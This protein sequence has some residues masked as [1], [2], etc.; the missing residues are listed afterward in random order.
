MEER[1]QKYL[2]DNGIASRRAAEEQIKLGNVKV[3]GETAVIGQKIDTENDTVE[4]CGKTVNAFEKKVYV[5]LNKPVGYVTTMHDE[6]NRKCVADLVEDVGVRIYPVGRLDYESEGLLIM[7][8]DGELTNRLTHP[9]YHKPKT[10]LVRV[11]G[12]VDGDMAERLSQPADIDGYI[13]KPAKVSV[14][15]SGDDGTLLSVTISEGRNRQIRK[16]CEKQNL[17]V[18]SLKR[19]SLGGIELGSLRAG[20]WRYLTKAEIELLRN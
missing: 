7:T 20:Q 12:T 10:Y 17:K 15:T 3:N 9:R 14:V 4:Y 13:T 16:M 19:I 6:K 1:L 8:N 18:L 5:M 2:S 11:G